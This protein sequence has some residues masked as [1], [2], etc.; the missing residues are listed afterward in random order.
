MTSLSYAQKNPTC[1]KYTFQ[2]NKKKR[3]IIVSYEIGKGNLYAT[4]QNKAEQ[5][6]E[7]LHLI[8]IIRI[9]ERLQTC[10]ERYQQKFV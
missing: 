7:S 3:N 1:S 4:N 10:S 8:S 9:G 6:Y 5:G 2:S